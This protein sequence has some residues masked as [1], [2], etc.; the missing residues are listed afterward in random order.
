[1]RFS[2][3]IRIYQ[4]CFSLTQNFDFGFGCCTESL[5][6][7]F[8]LAVWFF[9]SKFD[10]VNIRSV[11]RCCLSVHS[12]ACRLRVL[13]MSAQIASLLLLHSMFFVLLLLC[14]TH[15]VHV[16]CWYRN[17]PY[18]FLSRSPFVSSYTH[19]KHRLNTID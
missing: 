16:G 17:N 2:V 14:V 3:P 6:V 18:T 1:M 11:W 8:H 10:C 9:L 7:L 19:N 13:L 4:F 15:S 12:C 5:F